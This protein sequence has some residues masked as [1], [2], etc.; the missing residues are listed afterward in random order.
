MF[1]ELGE[2]LKPKRRA[3][4]AELLAA[5]QLVR[6]WIWAGFKIPSDT[7]E[8]ATTDAEIEKEYGICRWSALVN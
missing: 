2:L 7:L 1:C 3:I 6:L 8:V 5:I 4:G